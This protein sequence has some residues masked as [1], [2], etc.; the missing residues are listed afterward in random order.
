VESLKIGCREASNEQHAKRLS[1]HT[2]LKQATI[3]EVSTKLKLTKK[4]VESFGQGEMTQWSYNTSFDA[5]LE[6]GCSRRR[7]QLSTRVHGG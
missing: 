4:F 3:Y 7:G 5:W 1:E 6:N 2:V